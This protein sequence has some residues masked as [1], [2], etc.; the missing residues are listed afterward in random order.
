MQ[1]KGST[2]KQTPKSRPQKNPKNLE[3]LSPNSLMEDDIDVSPQNIDMQQRPK[4]LKRPT[5]SVNEN[6]ESAFTAT[7]PTTREGNH[8]YS[9]S[10]ISTSGGRAGAEEEALR[11]NNLLAG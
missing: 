3:S 10:D 7:P 4:R 8:N 2:D 5:K 1:R 6:L 11:H 9:M